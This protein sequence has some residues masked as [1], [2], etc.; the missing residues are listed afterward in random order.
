MF[1]LVG[2]GSIGLKG[3]FILQKGLYCLW[4]WFSSPALLF[5]SM[6]LFDNLFPLDQVLR[7]T[8]SYLIIFG[9]QQPVKD[10][11]L[12]EEEITES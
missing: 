8:C 1:K 6:I 12:G 11:A 5:M 2:G 9:L 10:G 3:G 7:N 4:P